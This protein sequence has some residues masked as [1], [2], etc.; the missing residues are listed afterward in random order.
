MYSRSLADCQ[1][2]DAEGEARRETRVSGEGKLTHFKAR[3]ASKHGER[4][5]RQESV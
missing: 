5:E 2:M 3:R 1:Q 4:G